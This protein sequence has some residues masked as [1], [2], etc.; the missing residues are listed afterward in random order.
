MKRV[1]ARKALSVLVMVVF[2]LQM[3]FVLPPP[4][5]SA[6]EIKTDFFFPSRRMI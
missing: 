5:A 4:A 2:L 1:G 6:R 3:S